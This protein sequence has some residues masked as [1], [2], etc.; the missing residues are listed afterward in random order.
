MKIVMRYT[1]KLMKHGNSR[2]LALPPE[3][4]EELGIEPS[5]TMAIY[6]LEAGLLIIPL[7]SLRSGAANNL[8][9]ALAR[10]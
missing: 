4:R 8:L 7:K 10:S 9:E 1:R 5:D 6:Q 3:T 2:V